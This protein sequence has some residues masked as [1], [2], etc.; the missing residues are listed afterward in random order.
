MPARSPIAPLAPICG[1][2]RRSAARQARRRMPALAAACICAALLGGCAAPAPGGSLAMAEHVVRQR[3]R[4]DLRWVRSEAD[5]Q[6]VDQRVAALLA[7][8]LYA[9]AA[10]QVA[11][12]N[13]RGLQARFHGLGLD[14]ARLRQAA[15]LPNPGFTFSRLV[16]ADEKEIERALHLDLVGLLTWPLRQ[17]AQGRQLQQARLEAALAA[18]TLAAQARKAYFSAVAAEQAMQM[19]GQVRKSAETSAELARRLGRVG[20]WSRLQVAREQAFLAETLVNLA[21]AQRTQM[22]SRERLIRLLG[23]WGEQTQFTLP[24]RLPELPAQAAEQPQLEQTALAGRL[25]LQAARLQAE[26]TAKNLGL[27]RVTRMVNVLEFGAVRNSA[28]GA[29][30][31]AG[32]EIS[33]EIPLFDWGQARVAQAQAL[34]MQ[35]V[36]R[37]AQTAIEARSQI[38]EAYQ[39]YRIAYDVARHYRDEVVP[40]A[41]GMSDDNLLRYN[42]MQ[43]GVFELLA[44]A[45]ART[46]ASVAAIEA[47]RDFWIAQADLDLAL[48]GPV[49]SSFDAPAAAAAGRAEGPAASH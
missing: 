37:A 19:L 42:G 46:A 2:A 32:Y 33:I 15:Q 9:E 23:L 30:A 40:G 47:L 14:E 5:Q 36:Q 34:Y 13:H 35:S 44:D 45:R 1:P 3:L 39:G 48:S 18:L 8:P 10:V 38:R 22:A 28:S 20:N 7:G 11:L 6:Q 41:A 31:Q 25:D 27:T 24:P 17:R 21:R 12:L 29:P 49:D 4:M 26:A 16:R 43:I